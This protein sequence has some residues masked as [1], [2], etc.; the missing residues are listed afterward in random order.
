MSVGVAR[1]SGCRRPPPWN[2]PRAILAARRRPAGGA[3]I[4]LLVV[5]WWLLTFVVPASSLP[6]PAERRPAARRRLLLRARAVVLRPRRHGP[7]RQHDLHRGERL[8]RG[9]AS[10]GVIGR[11]GGP[12]HRPLRPGA[13]HRRSGH[14][15]RRHRADPGGGT[16][17]PHLVR[18]RPGQLG[19]PGAAL[20]GGD[21]LRLSPSGPPTISTRST[22]TRP[23]R[24]APGRG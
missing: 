1:E 6:S 13:G 23:A 15:D 10:G 18:R 9:P 8:H 5:V 12:R 11:R 20:R 17:L 4:V 7:P 21:P 24:S 14:A 19:A 3:G 22:R 2:R 16:L